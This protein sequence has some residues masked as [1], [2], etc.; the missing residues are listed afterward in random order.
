MKI[1]EFKAYYQTFLPAEELTMFVKEYW[2]YDMKG[3]IA[4]GETRELQQP[5]LFPEII[6]KIGVNYENFDIKRNTVNVIST[7]TI[8]G[9]QNRAKASKRVDMNERLLLIGIKLEYAGIYQLLNLPLIE[10]YNKSIPKEDISNDFLNE[11]EQRLQEAKNA[12]EIVSILN[13]ELIQYF[14][15]CN[16][17]NECLRFTSIINSPESTSLAALMSEPQLNY[18]YLE[19]RFRKYIGIT[20]KKYFKLKR[21]LSFYERWLRH[22]HYNYIDLVYEFD[23]FDQNHLIKDFKAVLNQSPNQFKNSKNKHFT[24]YIIRHKLNLLEV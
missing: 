5:I 22:D 9:I 12:S 24:E 16:I 10:L 20:P 6:F 4:P 11:L 3:R 23:F 15:I 14:R 7:S 2:V 17:D 19:R 8:C 21:Y 1:E 18:K 13:R